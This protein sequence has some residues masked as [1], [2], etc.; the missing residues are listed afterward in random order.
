[1][2][3]Q[4][5]DKSKFAIYNS[6]SFFSFVCFHFLYSPFS[7]REANEPLFLCLMRRKFWALPICQVAPLTAPQFPSA[8]QTVESQFIIKSIKIRVQNLAYHQK[9]INSSI[10]SGAASNKSPKSGRSR[11]VRENS[12]LP[13]KPRAEGSNPS[14]PAID[15]G[16]CKHLQFGVCGL[17]PCQNC[18]NGHAL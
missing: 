5:L 7:N 13:P 17:F 4:H 14:A 15:Q 1:M 2:H 12:T 11:R 3:C 18:P 9:S 10:I 16:A 8:I 6:N